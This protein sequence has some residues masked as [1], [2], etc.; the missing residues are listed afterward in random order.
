M[1]NYHLTVRCSAAVIIFTLIQVLYSF[2][3]KGFSGKTDHT[4]SHKFF[5]EQGIAGSEQKLYCGVA[6]VLAIRY[7]STLWVW[8]N[9][10]QGQLGNGTNAQSLYPIAVSGM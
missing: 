6:H 1:S 3:F 8:G 7:D 9:N 10:S 2:D 4:S 5:K